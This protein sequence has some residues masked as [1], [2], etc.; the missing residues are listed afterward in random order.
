MRA[1]PI[2]DLQAGEAAAYQWHA[3]S[4]A[5]D[6]S[7]KTTTRTTSVTGGWIKR[8]A[9]TGRFVEVRTDRGAAKASAA[10]EAAVRKASSRRGAA[11]RRLADR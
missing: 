3:C 11:L 2:K 4:A 10:S 5:S 7:M 9:A 6:H 1:D 8:D